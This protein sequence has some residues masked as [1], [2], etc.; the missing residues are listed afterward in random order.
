MSSDNRKV[1]LYITGKVQGVFFRQTLKVVAKK[2]NSRGW[3]RNLE[4]GRVEAMIEGRNVDISHI[5]E[6]CNT[7]PAN[8][9]VEQVEIKDEKY[10]KDEFSD[11]NVLY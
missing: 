5:I 7:G 8:S 1:H 9:R 6:W 2:N 3:V 10:I 11:F 4:D